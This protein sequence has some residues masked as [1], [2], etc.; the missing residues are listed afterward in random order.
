MNAIEP[1]VVIFLSQV[2]NR[3][4]EHRQAIN[5]LASARLAG[6]M[7]AILRQELDSMVRVIYLLTQTVE[8]RTLL[9]NT[10]VEGKKWPKVT[11]KEMVDVAQKL[12]GWTL[13][14]YKF[15]CAFIHL[16]GL[17]D[18]KQ[19]DP[20]FLLSPDE[21]S[22]ILQ[23]CRHYHGGPMQEDASFD[24][25]VSFFPR[26]FEKIASNLDFYLEMLERCDALDD[27]R[28]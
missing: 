9:I 6:Q 16:S 24:D 5:L 28:A 25:L 11:D 1:Q 17:H 13:S 2:R 3:S 21:R 10:S 8:R 23:H 20:L 12:Q 14:V 27:L 22:A 4:H 15:G 7:T 18:Y 19:R 26:V